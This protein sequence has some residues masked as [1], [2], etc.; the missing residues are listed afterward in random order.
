MF[1]YP[2]HE[3]VQGYFHILSYFPQK[4]VMCKNKKIKF[5][6]FYNE[7][8]FSLQTLDTSEKVKI[9]DKSVS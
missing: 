2:A 5:D 7:K 3:E 1:I 6:W 8:L 9:T 4:C